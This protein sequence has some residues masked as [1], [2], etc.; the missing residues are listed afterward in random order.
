MF[1]YYLLINGKLKE[2][3]TIL[4]GNFRKALEFYY[5]HKVLNFLTATLLAKNVS[6]SKDIRN[7]WTW[8]KKSGDLF[9]II[10]S[11]T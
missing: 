7:V 6:W 1:A 11:Y 10:S 2:N 5:R 3:K 9:S 4:F 8:T